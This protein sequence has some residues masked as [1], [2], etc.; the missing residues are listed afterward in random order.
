MRDWTKGTP[1]IAF[2]FCRQCTYTWYH[3]RSFCPQCGGTNPESRQSDGRGHI[4]AVTVIHRAPTLELQDSAPYPVVLVRVDEGF[5]VM[6][7]GS[8]Q[9]L[10]IGARVVAEYRPFGEH[11]YIPVFSL[12]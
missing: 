2:Q 9:N 6:G 4:E 7:H 8:S 3:E 1:G 5:L 10:T 12:K 11:E